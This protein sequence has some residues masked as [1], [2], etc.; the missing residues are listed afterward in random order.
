MI[1]IIKSLK[2]GHVFIPIIGFLL[3]FIFQSC[4]GPTTK[5]DVKE[6][7]RD[8][9]EAIEDA[10]EATEKARESKNDYYR[11]HRE[12]ALRELTKR[13]NEIDS[14]ISELA[15]TSQKSKNKDAIV[16]IQSAILTLQKEKDDLDKRFEII[17]N[18]EEDWSSSYE[19]INASITSI[20]TELN[21]LNKSLEEN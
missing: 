9:N 20:E 7:L 15:K 16:N 19:E 10:A 2:A 21:K 3:L 12:E 13:S 1:P 14:R 6:D 8:A 11:E 17:K 18:R 5:E 4:S